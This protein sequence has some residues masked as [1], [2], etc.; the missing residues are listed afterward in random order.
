MFQAVSVGSAISWILYIIHLYSTSISGVSW[1]DHAPDQSILPLKKRPAGTPLLGNFISHKNGCFPISS[2]Y[3]RLFASGGH[4]IGRNLSAKSRPGESEPVTGVFSVRWMAEYRS[5]SQT[6]Y[7]VVRYRWCSIMKSSRSGVLP[8]SYSS[9][10]WG[11]PS[12]H[13]FTTRVP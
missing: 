7:F 6:G 5:V 11:D 3:F 1:Q 2:D 10:S 9:L 12:D 13:A 4:F 8:G